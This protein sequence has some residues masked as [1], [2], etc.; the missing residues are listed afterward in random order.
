MSRLQRELRQTKP[1]ASPAVEAHLAIIRTA[2]LLSRRFTALLKPHDLSPAQYN[3]LRILRGH[4]RQD[5]AAR[6][7]PCGTIAERLISYDPDVTR[8]VD[9]LVKAG[10]AVRDRDDRDRRVVLVRIAP[11]GL[12]LLDRLDVAVTGHD[13]AGFEDLPPARIQTLIDTLAAIRDRL[14]PEPAHPPTPAP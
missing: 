10:L 9:R 13:S 11:A 14:D 8:L 2:D 5:P 1:F 7:M 12:D 6:G 3:V 4:H